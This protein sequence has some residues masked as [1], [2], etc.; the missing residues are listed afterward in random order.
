VPGARSALPI[1]RL[2]HVVAM[3]RQGGLELFKNI[4]SQ[5]GVGKPM[6]DGA[7]CRGA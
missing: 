1:H 6:D 3:F 5:A 2:R 7:P 4:F